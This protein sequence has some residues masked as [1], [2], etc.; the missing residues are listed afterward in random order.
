MNVL[1]QFG[2]R[3]LTHS[4]PGEQAARGNRLNDNAWFLDREKI[5]NL[6][7]NTL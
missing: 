5:Y 2:H 4:I 7:T 6:Y 3:D 1:F